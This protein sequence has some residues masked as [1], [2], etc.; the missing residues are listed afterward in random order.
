MVRLADALRKSNKKNGKKSDH[1]CVGEAKS[2]KS[3]TVSHEALYEGLI[4]YMKEVGDNVRKRERFDIQKGSNLINVIVCNPK[5]ILDDLHRL[6]LLSD[7]SKTN[8]LATHAAN[9]S[10]NAII[11][12]DGL[13]YPRARQIGLGTA[14]LFHDLGMCALEMS[15][16]F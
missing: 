3:L 1:V 13:G 10:I 14:A 12:G 4:N 15:A 16:S 8:S 9:L 11:M 5:S 6:T 7:G 2:L